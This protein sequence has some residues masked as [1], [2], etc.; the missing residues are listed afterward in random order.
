MTPKYTFLLPAYKARYFEE[1]LRSIKAQTYRDFRVLVSDD[2]S[3][4]DLQSIFDRVCADDPRFTFRR[5]KENMGGR[6]LVAHWNLLVE[7]CNTEWLIMASDDDVYEPEFLE[8]MDELQNKYPNVDLLHA[9]PQEIDESGNLRKVGSMYEEYAPQ[10]D[11]LFFARKR[12]HIECLANYAYRTA[13]LKGKGGFLDFPAAWFSDTA[14]NTFM[15]HNG[16]AS[17]SQVVFSFRMSTQNISSQVGNQEDARKKMEATLA[18]NTWMKNFMDD[19]TKRENLSPDMVLSANAEYQRKVRACY[20]GYI[21]SCVPAQFFRFLIACPSEL[22]LCRLRMLAH[23]V[24][25]RI[26]NRIH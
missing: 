23:Y 6:S 2:C 21:H 9:R 15:A 11:F 25:E 22:G 19:L 24:K 8:K 16:C 3:P 14:T 17:T 20:Q 5:N 12:D 4:E 18:F 26:Y 1:A 7:M 13:V 10:I